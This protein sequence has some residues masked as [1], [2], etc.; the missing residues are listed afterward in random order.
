MIQLLR[1]LFLKDSREPPARKSAPSPKP[2]RPDAA[3]DYRAVSLES[4]SAC[5]AV[6]GC[7]GKR[8]LMREVPRLP[9]AGCATPS[10]CTCRFRKHA[11]RRE[12]DRRIFGLVE[13]SRWYAGSERR[14]L[15]CRRVAAAS[16]A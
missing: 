14:S 10:A 7:A 2:A 15:R 12:A 5:T 8:Y 16:M 13:T 11:D 6:R 1:S 9:L 4:R 3:A